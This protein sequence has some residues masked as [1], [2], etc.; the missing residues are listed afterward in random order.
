M[1]HYYIITGSEFGAYLDSKKN[2]KKEDFE[3]AD[4]L[5]EELK[6]SEENIYVG[7]YYVNNE[8][9]ETQIDSYNYEA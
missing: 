5:F 7:F 8:G 2:F 1:E 4:K 6:N 9:I 3:L